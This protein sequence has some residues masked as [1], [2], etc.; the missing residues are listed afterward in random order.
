MIKMIDKKWVQVNI[1]NIYIE[2]ELTE[3]ELINV[4][5]DLTDQLEKDW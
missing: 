5:R 1:P 3:V 2:V 4:I